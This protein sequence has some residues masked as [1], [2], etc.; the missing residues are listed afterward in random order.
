M[1]RRLSGGAALCRAGTIPRR[2]QADHDLAPSLHH[3]CVR[4]VCR[5]GMSNPCLVAAGLTH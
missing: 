3:R 4:D 2:D 1:Q 5:Q